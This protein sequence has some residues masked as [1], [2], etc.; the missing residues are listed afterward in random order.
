MTKI[1]LHL[2]CIGNVMSKTVFI[3]QV[4]PLKEELKVRAYKD[5]EKD[6]KSRDTCLCFPHALIYLTEVKSQEGHDD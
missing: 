6:L 4:F 5:T 3:Y 2:F 1:S